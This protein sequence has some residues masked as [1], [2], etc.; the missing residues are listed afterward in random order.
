MNIKKAVNYVIKD[1][2]YVIITLLFPPLK[3]VYIIIWPLN[4]KPLVFSFM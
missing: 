3:R 4:K 2:P 1:V